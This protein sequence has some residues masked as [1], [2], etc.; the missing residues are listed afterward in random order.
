MFSEETFVQLIRSYCYLFVHAGYVRQ[1]MWKPATSQT[2]LSPS[3][4]SCAFLFRYKQ[5]LKFLNIQTAFLEC[6][7]LINNFK[8]NR[9][10]LIYTICS[11][12]IVMHARY[13]ALKINFLNFF[14]NYVSLMIMLRFFFK[15][16][17]SVIPSGVFCVRCILL[18]LIYS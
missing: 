18:R 17:A 10:C 4:S 12:Y 13:H 3:I 8:H 15:K 16:V 7:K 6:V 5:H 9:V 14:V 1:G 2:F 11:L